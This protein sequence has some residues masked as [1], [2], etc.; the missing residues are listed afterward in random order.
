[1]QKSF[2]LFL[3]GILNTCL[4]AQN[5][6]LIIPVGHSGEIKSVV[7]NH[8]E[9]KLISCASDQTVKIWEIKTGRL[10]ANIK[11]T[12]RFYFALITHDE[13]KLIT[14]SYGYG[15][16][17]M[18]GI[19]DISTQKLIRRFVKGLYIDPEYASELEALQFYTKEGKVSIRLS[20]GS[21]AINKVLSDN[22]SNQYES[23]PG[24]NKKSKIETDPKNTGWIL[25]N[26]NE[27]VLKTFPFEQSANGFTS[28]TMPLASS[29]GNKV[30]FTSNTEELVRLWDRNQNKYH[31]LTDIDL[32]APTKD[33]KKYMMTTNVCFSHDSKL[34]AVAKDYT[35]SAR[36]YFPYNS[37]V[38]QIWDTE[39][40]QLLAEYPS[41]F[42]NIVS[43]QF[44]KD[45]SKLVTAGKDNQI[46]LWNVKGNTNKGL[47]TTFKGYAFS[48]DFVINQN[49]NEFILLGNNNNDN[50]DFLVWDYMNGKMSRLD[51]TQGLGFSNDGKYF[52]KYL[53]DLR[54]LQV[55]NAVD[56]EM[57]Y[58]YRAPDEILSVEMQYSQLLVNMGYAVIQLDMN[59]PNDTAGKT[60]IKYD[61]KTILSAKFYKGG[62]VL[63]LPYSVVF[64]NSKTGAVRNIP[65]NDTYKLPNV[66]V[67]MNK[68]GT[69]YFVY[70]ISPYDLQGANTEGEKLKYVPALRDT[71]GYL[72]TDITNVI[73]NMSHWI[74]SMEFS[75]NDKYLLSASDGG[76]VTLW[77]AETGD[78]IFEKNLI[79]DSWG[80]IYCK[81]YKAT[82]SPDDSQIICTT[83]DGSIIL[84][85]TADGSIVR[86]MHTDGS[87]VFRNVSFS[88]DGKYIISATQG[89]KIS[90]WN[91]QTGELLYSLLSVNSSDYLVIDKDGRFE[92]SEL[93]R[94]SLYLTCGLEVIELEQFKSRGRE[95][96]L[97]P[98][99]M[100]IDPRPITAKRIADIDI[101]NALPL[102]SEP[103]KQNGKYLFTIKPRNKGLGNVELYV[104]NNQIKSYSVSD[105]N[106]MPGNV[107]QLSVDEKEIIPYF[108]SND[109]AHGKANIVE[110]IVYVQAYTENNELT[111]R[112]V[113]L[114]SAGAAGKGPTNMYIV[115]VGV[116]AY[117]GDD[118][119][120]LHYAS[121]DAQRLSNTLQLSARKLLNKENETTDHVKSFVYT[122][123]QG[124]GNLAAKTIIRDKMK[125][126]AAEITA[127]DIFVFFFAGHGVLIDGR[128]ELY[129][130]TTEAE[131]FEI[132]GVENEVAISSSELLD[133]MR[134]IK[135]NKKV[136]VLD[137]CHSGEAV[138]AFASFARGS[139]ADQVLALEN[140]KDK[141]GTLLLTASTSGQLAYEDRVL[142]QGL[143]TYQLLSAIKNEEGLRNKFIDVYE[144][145]KT[146]QQHLD[147]ATKNS[148]KRQQPQILGRNNFEV[149]YVDED[150]KNSIRFSVA[151]K[152]MKRSAVFFDDDLNSDKLDLGEDIDREI[153]NRTAANKN[154]PY[155]FIENNTS[156][157]SFSVRGK[158]ETTGDM[159]NLKLRLVVKGASVLPL[160]ISGKVADKAGLVRMIVDKVEEYFAND[161]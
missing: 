16:R 98:K 126:L 139:N 58:T 92:G 59:N 109:S 31:P 131:S 137:A 100:G 72:V 142:G 130:L 12:T 159:L 8:D 85:Q 21:I 1:M 55:Y 117:K 116:N 94:K 47:L 75:H 81:I 76:Y 144:W 35:D 104:N 155:L 124:D 110:N 119:M 147:Q 112:G 107:Y 26:G 56:K 88:G 64:I 7:F 61:N 22:L 84:L 37:G 141:S 49:T 114:V 69:R 120:Q 122:T 154:T 118:K 51:K 103:V 18:I 151:K 140:L 152:I 5:P 136:I 11:D 97:V 28:F 135:A 134:T 89:G 138:N 39:K 30:V 153:R 133:W 102:V 60:I 83:Q 160:N 149:G 113:G 79:S 33:M 68:A 54:T 23:V 52:F 128:K 13:K 43:I 38:L 82:F 25:K 125:A 106:R 66:P 50:D 161:K 157:Q 34:L 65:N 73:G 2:I 111:A 42:S 10:L 93:A 4:F 62:V 9:T 15:N 96:D 40:Y 20:D 86:K 78:V 46:R 14:G 36:S 77:N 67:E 115:S 24:V 6:K 70:S 148:D 32:S 143:L 95:I 19:W 129:L 45:D 27:V 48:S 63:T 150:V 105:L 156:D 158:Y 127:N 17:S 121:Y 101:C 132:K 146:A 71:S 108:I 87:E 57:L 99:I 145:F 53:R 80:F 90:L 91:K 74:N 3:A 29:D 41:H 44:N 123:L